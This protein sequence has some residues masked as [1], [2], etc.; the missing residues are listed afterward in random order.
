MANVGASCVKQVAL[1]DRAKYV[2]YME[3]RV[4]EAETALAAMQVCD[5]F[6]TTAHRR[7]V[8]LHDINA[9]HCF[10]DKQAPKR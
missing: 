7:A 1:T 10:I 8:I 3:A 5:S 2:S 4:R 6:L 9:L